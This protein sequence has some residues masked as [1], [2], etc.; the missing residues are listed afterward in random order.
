MGGKHVDPQKFLKHFALEGADWFPERLLAVFIEEG[1]ST[2]GSTGDKLTLQ[3]FRGGGELRGR[4][5]RGSGEQSFPSEGGAGD[6]QREVVVPAQ[7]SGSTRLDL[8]PPIL[9]SKG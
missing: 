6:R 5:G 3:G 8:P 9:P 2:A 4:S 1:K 7:I